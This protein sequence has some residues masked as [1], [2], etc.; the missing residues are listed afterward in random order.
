MLPEKSHKGYENSVAVAT[1][2]R[3]EAFET[4]PLIARRRFDAILAFRLEE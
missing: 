1:R 2:T 3:M 4:L